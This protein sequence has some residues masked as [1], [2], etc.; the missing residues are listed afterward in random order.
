LDARAATIVVMIA[1][2]VVYVRVL[3]EVAVISREFLKV[4]AMP[5]GIMM[6]LT[7]VPALVVWFRVRRQ[8]A[9][10][11]EQEN[12]TQ[13][14]SAVVFGLMYALVLFA[15]SAAKEHFGGRGLVVVAG[16]SGL[17]DMDAITLS[18]AR[19]ARESPAMLAEGWRLIVVA[20]I[21]NLVFKSGIA[22]VLGGWRLLWRIALLFSFPLAGGVAL[23]LL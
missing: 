17:T 22:G 9:M 12:P 11:P 6:V 1:S 5:I 3:I 10:M 21:A 14:K 13:L 20:A 16:L 15:L 7:L 19:M 4:V 23:L 8:P 2:T 18:A